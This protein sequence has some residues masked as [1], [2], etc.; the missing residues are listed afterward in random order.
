MSEKKFHAIGIMSGT[1]LDGLDLAYCR[2][3]KKKGQ[4]S[5]KIKAAQTL[6]YNA[7]WKSKLGGAH[8]LL[9]KDLMQL[10]AAYGRW[11]GDRCQNFIKQNKIEKL[12]LI[13]S[14]GH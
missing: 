8:L 14:H 10:H 6:N 7:A 4:W 9:G 3:T 12:D 1:S 11:I 5:F 13:A 2:F